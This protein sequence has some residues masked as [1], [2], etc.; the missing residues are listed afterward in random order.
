M[1]RSMN[2]LRIW[3]LF[4]ALSLAASLVVV[5]LLSLFV[6]VGVWYQ[7]AIAVWLLLC[8]SSLCFPDNIWDRW[9]P[10]SPEEP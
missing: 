3:L 5:G 7:M 1:N 6:P 8:Y 2:R 10:E 4:Y 9:I